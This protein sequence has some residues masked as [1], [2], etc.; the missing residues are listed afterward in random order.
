M[1][2]VPANL[3]ILQENCFLLATSNKKN[4]WNRTYNIH[5]DTKVMAGPFFPFFHSKIDTINLNY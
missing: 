1:Q 4:S 3:I 2:K 5:C